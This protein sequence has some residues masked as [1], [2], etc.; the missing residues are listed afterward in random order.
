MDIASPS[1]AERGRFQEAFIAAAR[2]TLSGWA[3]TEIGVRSVQWSARREPFGD[4]FAR[5]PLRFATAE[6][7]LVL[8]FPEAMAMALAARILTGVLDD[9]DASVVHV[10]L[11][12]MANILA[13]QA[14]ALLHGTSH[15]FTFAT[16]VVSRAGPEDRPEPGDWLVVVFRSDAGEFALQ[17]SASP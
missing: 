17:V 14:K 6:G 9:W 12:E 4:L 16:P 11:G 1:D 13:G 10:Y 2:A 5:L 7:T 15:H 3:N 8:G